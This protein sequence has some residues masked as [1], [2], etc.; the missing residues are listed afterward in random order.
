MK[1]GDGGS[2][3]P[4]QV[5]ML[6]AKPDSLIGSLELTCWKRTGSLSCSLT[7]TCM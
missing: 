3:M 6:V 2:E 5:K 7:I 1:R 4:G